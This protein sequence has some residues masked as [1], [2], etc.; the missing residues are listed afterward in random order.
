MAIGYQFLIDH[1]DLD[2]P[3]LRRP[4][5]IGP[6]TRIALATDHIGVPASVAPKS[7]Q[8][9]DHLLFALKH[10]GTHLNVLLQTLKRLPAADVLDAIRSTPSGAYV[11][12]LGFLWEHANGESL[13]DLPAIGG[14]TQTVFD[15][16]R[17]VTGEHRRNAKWR[18]AFNGLGSLDWCAT[19]ERSRELDDAMGSDLPERVRTYAAGLTDTVRDRVLSWAYLSETRDSFA[20][21]REAPTQTR[22][23]KFVELLKRAGDAHPLDEEYLTG[24]QQATV[25]NPLD[26][27]VGFRGGQNHLG[28]PGTGALAV[29]YVPPPPELARSLMRTLMDF[30]NDP[31]RTLDP[32]VAAGLVSFGFVFIH[33]FM[34]GNGRLSRFLF[35]QAL[36]RRK[37]L[38]DGLILP[39]SVAMKKHESDYL[40]ALQSFSV[41]AR[42]A[43][44]VR[45]MD[46]D[47]YDLA[48]R[49][50]DDGAV[51]RYWDATEC[52]TFGYRMAE[53]ALEVE[54]RD[55]VAYLRRYDAIFKAVD[56]AF[57]IRQSDLSQLVRH[58]IEQGGRVSNNRRKQF[59]DRIDPA[60]FEFLERVAADVLAES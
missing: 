41:P 19:I 7:A 27:A 11:R 28:G 36:C 2:V 58:A 4:A 25:A 38:P 59:A 3:P 14:N 31:P 57:D 42:E 1:L 10:E 53:Q 37:A 30:A 34:D 16:A 33:P 22:Q 20:I 18:V 21:E 5:R 52:V 44:E 12:V 49:W 56:D 35:H 46:A 23:D 13:T 24:L 55:E 48:Y 51:Y 39:V 26:L 43:W 6:L 54:L 17:Y 32:I 60:A 15:A 40:R 29:T 50:K 47:R 9:I 45:W 8:V